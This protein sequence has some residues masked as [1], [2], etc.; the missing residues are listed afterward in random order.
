MEHPNGSSCPACGQVFAGAA[1]SSHVA[2][3]NAIA[4]PPSPA[5]H[6]KKGLMPWTGGKRLL[7]HRLAAMID[8]HRH[9]CYVEPFVGAGGVFFVRQSR[10]RA[11]VIND[12]NRD[13]V[14]LFRVLRRHPDALLAELSTAL[15][16]RAEFERLRAQPSELLTD[17][18]R[19]ARFYALQRMSFGGKGRTFGVD[20]GTRGGPT[21]RLPMPRLETELRAYHARLSRV[22]I[23]C[24]DWADLIPRYDRPYTLFYL[25][26]PYVGHETDYGRGLFTPADHGRL[27]TMLRALKGRFILSLN[28][29]ET[30]RALYSWARL[31]PVDTT[32]SGR[33][34]QPAKRASEL[35][36]DNL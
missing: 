23:E 19:A 21:A 9:H 34:K 32:Y 31:E 25:D 15:H 7:A 3:A 1:K 28:D 30:S 13:L 8:E 6:P 5:D 36:I 35:I 27:A 4:A 22:T 17:I 20:A 12:A 29:C 33:A 14:T 26:P 2:S 11:E 24:L 16:A 10:P 18:E